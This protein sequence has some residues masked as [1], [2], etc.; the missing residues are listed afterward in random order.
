M[1]L[2]SINNFLAWKWIWSQLI[3]IQQKESEGFIE[4]IT[5]VFFLTDSLES[6]EMF[7]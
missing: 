3:K 5:L 7:K 2:E 6:N 1:Y 4:L